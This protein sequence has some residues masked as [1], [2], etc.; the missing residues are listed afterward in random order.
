MTTDDD[1]P[2]VPI[3][4]EA[5]GTRSRVPLA[6]LRESLETH[7]QHRHD[8]EEV[9][10]VDPVLAEELADHVAEDLGLYGGDA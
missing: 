2:T 7:N 3:V 5:C 9:A 4:C 6:D 10:Q 8:G 1:E